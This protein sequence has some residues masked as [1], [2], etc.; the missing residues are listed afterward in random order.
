MQNK[1]FFFIVIGFM[2]VATAC[3]SRK[4]DKVPVSHFYFEKIEQYCGGAAPSQEMMDEI[5][6]PRPMTEATL[7]FYPSDAYGQSEPF[8]LTTDSKGKASA[9][10]PAGQYSIHLHSPE[11]ATRELEKYK[12]QNVNAE[13]MLEFLQMSKFDIPISFEED[14]EI[15]IAIMLDCNPCLPPAP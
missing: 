9:R 14:R 11:T 3:K 2:V 6:L 15:Q 5:S 10:I 1:R 13:C 12:D 4:T 8:I 7:Y